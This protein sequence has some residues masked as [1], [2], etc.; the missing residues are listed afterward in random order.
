MTVQPKRYGN[1]EERAAYKEKRAAVKR[2][3]EIVREANERVGAWPADLFTP[4]V[5]DLFA[6]LREHPDFVF[7]TIFVRDDM[8]LDVAEKIKA[9]PKR[10]EE[11]IVAAGFEAIEALS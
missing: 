4:S 7:G 3:R 1:A 8:E 6:Q 9:E 10:A 2:D 5:H 11:A